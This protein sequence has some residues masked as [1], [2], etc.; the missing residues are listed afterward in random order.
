MRK[1]T[2]VAAAAG[3]LLALGCSAE[4]AADESADVVYTNG[5]IYTVNEAQPWAEA[6]AIK[7]GK[8]LVVGANADVEAVLGGDTEVVDLDGRFAMPGLIDSHVHP[9]GAAEGWANLRISDPTDAEAI[10]EEVRAYSEANPDL[11][12]IR[13]EAW[14]LGVFPNN[15]P[16]K[17]PLDRIVP[18]RPVYLISQTGH[19]AW[20][21]SKALELAGITKDTPQ[22]DKFIFDTNPATGEPSG[23][24]REFAM[25]A[26][27]RAL[28]RAG[29]ERYAG[30]LGAV[31]AEFNSFGFTSL[32]PAEGAR[33][34]LEGAKHLEAQGGMTARLFPAWD[35]RTSH[36]LASSPE[37]ADELVATWESFATERIYPR[38][39]KIFYDGGPDSYTAL[40][41]E[42]YEGRP[43]FRGSSNL[44]KGEATEIIASFNRAGIGVL[45]HVLG[46]AGG[47]ELVD[48]YT[49]VRAENGPNDAP[50]HFSHAWMTRP[51]D[52]RRLARVDGVCIDFSP[53]LAYPAE[54]I[55]GSMA[56]PIGEDRYQT[57]FNAR[58]AFEAD[59]P[60]GFG[61]D[62]PS[63]LIPDPNGFHQMQSWITRRDPTDPEAGALNEGQGVTLEQAIRGLTL[64]G[65]QCLGFRWN[66]KLGSIEAGKLA[67]MIV[68]DRN[69]F[70]VPI[71]ELHRTQVLRTLVGGEVVYDRDRD[72][73]DDLI[74]EETF[75][76]T[77]RYI[78]E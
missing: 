56:P 18:D 69:P 31:L 47:R 65:A 35:W 7:D 58:A 55:R 50:L 53:V 34:W 27:E 51:E 14:N 41:F 71:E 68:T 54:E 59:L 29:P 15:S 3:L 32:I 28:T 23:T 38:Y 45:T 76:P 12:V 70:E 11:P 20:A 36:Y 4:Q 75:E 64:G 37:E 13:G 1:L 48:I 46:D 44:T 25:G 19:S 67:D 49:D 52:M 62:W 6:V 17:G 74:D 9:L 78:D 63:A 24:V 43:G 66:E 33:T 77:S 30:A 22:T 21:N 16:R 26:V 72:T 8:F 60:V 10:L 40:L 39:V 2:R 42:D 5:H 57:F 73:V 61:S